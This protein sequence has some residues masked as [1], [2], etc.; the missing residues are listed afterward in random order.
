MLS[1]PIVSNYNGVVGFEISD[2]DIEYIL[3]SLKQYF[4]TESV[5]F[6][7]AVFVIAE[8]FTEAFSFTEAV[9]CIES[10]IRQG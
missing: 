5:V 10:V 4:F 3:F 1:L 7:E 8:L 6:I 9:F 2:L